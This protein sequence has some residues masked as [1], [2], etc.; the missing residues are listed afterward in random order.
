MSERYENRKVRTNIGSMY[1]EF[2]KE[3]KVKYINHYETPKIP[4]MNAADR[5]Q[6]TSIPHI[7]GLGDRF[8]KL[9]DEF[10]DDPTFWWIISW[11]NQR[12]LES[13]VKIG[14]VIY[15]PTPLDDVLVFF[16]NEKFDLY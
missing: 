1:K 12:P 8:Y 6:I 16:N 9:A 15:I 4:F 11:Y 3:R 5:S 7:W 10:Y 2:F 13:D 14:S